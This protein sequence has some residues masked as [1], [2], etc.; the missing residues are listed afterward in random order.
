MLKEKSRWKKLLSFIQFCFIPLFAF[1]MIVIIPFISGVFNTFTDF[2]GIEMTKMVGVENYRKALTDK[3][4][5][6]T[7]WLTIQYVLCSVIF[8]NLIAFLLALLV[9]S[10]IKGK[11][12]L[13]SVFFMPNLIGGVI[14]GF[15]WQ[16]IF[17]KF[18]VYIGD[19]T[20]IAL[21]QYSWLIDTNKGFWA[22][23]IVSVWQM[24]GYLMLIYIA[25]FIGIP[26]EVLEASSI[27]GATKIKQLVHIRIPLMIQAFTIAVFLTI[28]NSFMVYDLNLSL[29][30]GGPY[31]STE[32]I[33][34]HIYNEAF[35]F[36]AYGTGQAKAVILFVI[37]AAVAI[38]QVLITKRMEV[39]S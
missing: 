15:I 4:F 23:V 5:W 22:M 25:G 17:S 11:H 19:A 21:F 6:S 8:T 12:F 35:L 7:L 3:T 24:S 32:M 14:L 29:T 13:R 37:V 28:K 18:M 1:L 38:T 16:F 30:N 36:Q 27:D 33:T 2:N 31:R 20:G 26:K 34:M 9:T 39:E 10:K